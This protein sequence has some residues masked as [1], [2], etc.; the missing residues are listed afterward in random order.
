M[1]WPLGEGS[2]VPLVRFERTLS[3]FEGG[4]SCRLV[5]MGVPVAGLEPALDRR[6]RPGLYRLGYTG[7]P[8]R[9]PVFA[10]GAA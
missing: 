10:R 5:Y 2:V 8:P 7:K 3:R 4:D 1:P 6:L 9:H